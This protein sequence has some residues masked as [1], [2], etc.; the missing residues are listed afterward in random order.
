MWR[1]PAHPGRLMLKAR[2]HVS[3]IT[4][5]SID[6]R[7]TFQHY[8]V[9]HLREHINQLSFML[10]G[11]GKIVEG[12]NILW[13]ERLIIYFYLIKL[14]I[15][16]CFSRCFQPSCILFT[17][18]QNMEISAMLWTNQMVLLY[19]ACLLRYLSDIIFNLKCML[20]KVGAEHPEFG[21]LCEVL[22]DIPRK[23][24][25]LALKE[26]IDPGNFLPR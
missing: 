7:L 15:F 25:V 8:L 18:T 5:H 1:T 9:G 20:L 12:V 24:D 22:Q 2:D 17:S 6:V 19:W 10:I 14:L 11:E 3:I 13:M 16:V 23:G 4:F 26:A 21:K